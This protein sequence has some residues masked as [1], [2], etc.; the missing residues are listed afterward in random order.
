MN[1]IA[2]HRGKGRYNRS[3]YRDQY[4]SRRNA[5]ERKRLNPD[6]LPDE[7]EH[8]ATKL[9]PAKFATVSIRC[10]AES[11]TFRVHRIGDKMLMRGKIQAASSVGRR[12]AL[13][14]EAVL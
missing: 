8:V 7:P 1:Y 10:G 3:F 14:L 4:E 6:P 12:I 11:V 13:V 2:S 5:K 9:P